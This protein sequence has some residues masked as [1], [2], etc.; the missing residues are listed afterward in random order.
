MCLFEPKNLTREQLRAGYIGLIK[1]LYLDTGGFYERCLQSMEHVGRPLFQGIYTRD[2]ITGVLRL[3]VA[4]GVESQFRWPFW[5]LLFRVLVR[6]PDKTPYAL[7]WAGYGLHYRMLT[8][9][10]LELE[11]ADT[12]STTSPAG[13]DAASSAAWVVPNERGPTRARP[14]DAITS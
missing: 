4:E 5:K 13:V 12:V 11:E 8:E 2:I 3:L 1:L 9:Q 6:F 14:T 10:M 7:R